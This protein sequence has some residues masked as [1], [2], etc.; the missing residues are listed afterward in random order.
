MLVAAFI[1]KIIWHLM[2][3]KLSLIHLIPLT[4]L[5]PP[6]GVMVCA[7]VIENITHS[8]SY[9]ILHFINELELNP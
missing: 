4:Y 1:V 3:R 6:G 2:G 9:S 8:T 7:C 5:A